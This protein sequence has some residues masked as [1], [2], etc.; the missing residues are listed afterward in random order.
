ML[1]HDEND[2]GCV[3]YTSDKYLKTTMVIYSIQ[4]VKEDDIQE[5]DTE[6]RIPVLRNIKIIQA[7]VKSVIPEFW[8]AI[9]SEKKD[10]GEPMFPKILS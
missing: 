3:R 8:V 5:L 4:C 2:H 7:V 9:C 6:W 1:L 10:D